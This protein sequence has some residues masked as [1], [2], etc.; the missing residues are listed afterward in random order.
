[1]L[2]AGAVEGDGS[3]RT[4]GDDARCAI[5]DAA[6]DGGAEPGRER[7]RMG[8]DEGVV[9][10]APRGEH[11]RIDAELVCNAGDARGDG[12]Q[13]EVDE[14]LRAGRLGQAFLGATRMLTEHRELLER[15]AAVL[16]EREA[17]DHEEIV[18]L[19]GARPGTDRLAPLAAET[20]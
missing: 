17:L 6:D 4:A 9:L 11:R 13:V 3:A 1:M 10:A 7:L 5:A 8:D 20:R 2:P 15:G 19:F 12:H 16:L 14:D 18:A